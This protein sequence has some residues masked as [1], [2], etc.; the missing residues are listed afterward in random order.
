MVLHFISQLPLTNKS[1][2][3]IPY[4]AGAQEKGHGH[5]VME[6][7]NLC[8]DVAFYVKNFAAH[9]IIYSDSVAM[10]K[11]PFNRWEEVEGHDA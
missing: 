1:W 2:S 3:V 4:Q 7:K 10:E 11:A 8:S 6:P 5:S 9:H